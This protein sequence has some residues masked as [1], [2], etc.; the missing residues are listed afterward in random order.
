MCGHDVWTCRRQGIACIVHAGVC[1]E[2]CNNAHLGCALSRL[3]LDM[4][5]LCASSVPPL[6]AGFPPRPCVAFP[7]PPFAA[8]FPPR[9]CVASSVPP[10]AAGFPP[11]PCVAS[12]V[13]PFAAG[14]PPR[15][16][17]ASPVPPLAAGFPP[18]SRV[19]T[20]AATF[21]ILPIHPCLLPQPWCCN[22]CEAHLFPPPTMGH[23]PLLTPW[24]M[25]PSSHHGSCPPPPTMGHAPSSHHDLNPK[26]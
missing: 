12:P 21:T 8:G 6:A 3:S 10:L 1:I 2:K 24:V 15:P 14:F 19:C 17:V 11:R 5:W 26:P 20:P 13:P 22:V 16:C 23:A 25:P 7:V 18:R 4:H 9:P